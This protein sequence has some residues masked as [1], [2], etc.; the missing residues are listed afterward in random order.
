MNVSAVAV[1][2]ACVIAFYIARNA[3]Y[4]GTITSSSSA[5]HGKLIAH[6]LAAFMPAAP[7]ALLLS[8]G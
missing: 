4:G 5:F 8:C 6:V 7:C 3:S 2:L 1:S